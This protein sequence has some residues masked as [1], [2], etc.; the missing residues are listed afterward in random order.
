MRPR[1]TDVLAFLAQSLPGLAREAQ[2]PYARKQLAI[3]GILLA[4][5]AQDMDR[6]VPR[7][8]EE[9]AAIRQLF[10]QAAK[11]VEDSDLAKE[12]SG[13][14]DNLHLTAL[15]DENDRLRE[16]LI[17]LHAQV[18]LLDGPDARALDE[19][20]WRELAQQNERRRTSYLKG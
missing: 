12:A 7:L 18:E 17:R 15:F 4:M 5:I 6:L 10:A 14:C 13:Q 9:A 20:I 3:S 8:I 16:R 2:S 11:L 19:A 1:P